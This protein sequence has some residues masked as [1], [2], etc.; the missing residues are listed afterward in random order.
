MTAQLNTIAA[1]Q[2]EEQINTA[3]KRLYGTVEDLSSYEN[4]SAWITNFQLWSLIEL[5][6]G[7]VFMLG[8]DEGDTLMRSLALLKFKKAEFKFNNKTPKVLTD[9]I[10][11]YGEDVAGFK[12]YG[13]GEFVNEQHSLW[14]EILEN[15]KNILEDH[16][17]QQGGEVKCLD[18]HQSL[19]F[20]EVM[21]SAL[22]PTRRQEL[23]VWSPINTSSHPGTKIHHFRPEYFEEIEEMFPTTKFKRRWKNDIE[24]ASTH[25]LP[26]GGATLVYQIRKGEKTESESV[27]EVAV[28]L[29]IC[30]MGD[31]YNRRQGAHVAYFRMMKALEVVRGNPMV[32]L[33]TGRKTFSGGGIFEIHIPKDLIKEINGGLEI[34]GS[35]FP[36]QICMA[37]GLMFRCHDMISE[38]IGEDS[39]LA[40]TLRVCISPTLA[41]LFQEFGGIDKFKD[42][43]SILSLMNEYKDKKYIPSKNVMHLSPSESGELI[44]IL[45]GDQQPSSAG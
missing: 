17:I 27:Y 18:P 30:S 43:G 20:P 2:T 3:M 8:W 40:N 22:R 29:S 16:G 25:L 31:R 21:K 23:L 14:G 10:S 35:A 4:N 33:E 7:L 26:V 28:G 1:P 24:K 19:F 42:W 36:N 39:L 9:V 38:H 32:I 12:Y 5:S 34:I 11:A 44:S 6:P 15:T 37:M 13:N 45:A 41:D